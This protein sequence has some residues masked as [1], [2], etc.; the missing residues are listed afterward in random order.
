[1][2]FPDLALY[3]DHVIEREGKTGANDN[4]MSEYDYGLS[5]LRKL[6][7]GDKADDT[8]APEGAEVLG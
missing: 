2:T 1:M 5:V 8:Q 3:L 4:R 7:D 6:L